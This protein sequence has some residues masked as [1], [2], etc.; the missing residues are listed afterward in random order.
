MADVEED[1]A[2][3]A[4][5]DD[6]SILADHVNAVVNG[7]V[8]KDVCILGLCVES[9]ADEVVP[10]GFTE[11]VMPNIKKMYIFQAFRGLQRSG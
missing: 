9:L 6:A 1:E 7:H 11:L 10:V 4:V 5:L 2:D 3:Q 8:L